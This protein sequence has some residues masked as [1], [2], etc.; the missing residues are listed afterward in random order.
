VKKLLNIRIKLSLL[1]AFLGMLLSTVPS[2]QAQTVQEWNDP[3][4]LSMSGSASNPAT[5]VD[6]T[7]VVHAIWA[8]QFDGY[9]Y[10]QSAD[11]LTWSPPAKVK[12]PFSPT[13]PPPMMFSDAKGTIHIFYL[14]DKNKL[15]Y[16]QTLPENLDSPPSW[17]VKLNLDSSVYD[18]DAGV[19]PQGRVHVAYLKNPAS[20][21]GPAGVFYRNS[22]D[23]GRTWAASNLLYESAYLHS[24]NA[25]TAHIRMAVSDRPED[26]KVYV[27][28]DDRPQ[29]R[30]SIT[31]SPD[32]GQNWEPVKELVA[33][34]A[35][36][37]FRTPF[38]GDIDVL[39]DKVLATWFVGEAGVS[40]TPYSWSSADGGE[41]WG[42]QTPILS[43]L[44]RCPE[45]SEFIPVDPNYSVELFTIQGDLSISAWNGAEWSDPEVQTGPSSIINP[46]TIEPVLL[47]CEQ[48]ASYNNRLIVAGCDEGGGGDVWY[49][50]RQL[51]SLDYLFPLP[52]E[53]SG[54]TKIISAP[55]TLS[56][57]SSVVDSNG[58][59]HAVWVQSSSSPT[60]AFAP[61]I[62]YAHWNGTEWT[63]PSPIF[64]NL[65]SLP[66]RLDLQIDSR[67]RLLLSWVNQK[68]GEL[69]F[70]W[71]NSE[72]ANIPVE[73]N[74]PVILSAE[75]KLT[76]SPDILVDATD[77]ILI[78][79]AITLNEGRGIYLIQSNDL[80]ETWSQPV[81]VF[82]AIAEGWEM[83]DQPKLA[84]TQD[85]TLHMLFTR[86]ALLGEPQPVGLY[87]SQSADGGVTWTP[88][89][90][91]SEQ[92]VQWSDLVAYQGILHR[93]WQEKNKLV[94]R[95]SHQTSSDGG[96]TWN[97]VD[98]ISSDADLNSIPAV[99]VDGT[100]N[101]H[102]VQV[103]GKDKQSFEEWEWSQDHWH[104]FE[105]RKVSTLDLNSPPVVDSGVTSNGRLYALIQFEKLME[106]GIETDLA[107]INRSL[108]IT[109]YVPPS[110]AVIAIASG[111]SAPLPTPV[112]QPTPTAGS[113]FADLNDPQPLANRNSIGLIL[114]IFLVVLIVFFIV[115]KK[116]KAPDKTQKP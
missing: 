104:L 25:E 100:G 40:C 78:A 5:V 89:E 53:W 92:P 91:V 101:L 107:S 60:D 7:G 108:E 57:I 111:L 106:K 73:W 9:K 49:I 82:D 33:P 30:I 96:K 51:D 71:S 74:Q 59:A 3:I 50:E 99:S 46:A 1:L 41:T 64:T 19:D 75:S 105:S 18:F 13:A 36:L 87:Y 31:I 17:R 79:Y 115:P 76:N 110:V 83:V 88:A 45:K 39:N 93:L 38:Y 62:Q 24:L 112:T 114:V 34:Q 52:S 47:G 55:R 65:D 16:A 35:N 95:T 56:S 81:K 8:D 84:V 113:P 80:G 102:F 109:D 22:V 61:V 63:R 77:R 6:S 14:D 54:D 32:G 94:A 116:S 43:D 2:S 86:Y 20:A 15:F 12:Y 29:K 98:K 67:Q 26:E 68:T 70:S 4:N 58:N 37:G 23:G 10:S 48:V 42:E 11:G 66:L 90:V 21:A 27:V 72:R 69:M 28:W 97:A 44:A 85:G 103:T